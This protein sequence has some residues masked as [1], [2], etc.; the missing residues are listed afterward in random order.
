MEWQNDYGFSNPS[1]A[2][3]G[4]KIRAPFGLFEKLRQI[5]F[6]G[7]EQFGKQ[8]GGGVVVADEGVSHEGEEGGVAVAG[9]CCFNSELLVVFDSG[10]EA[11][12]GAR[13]W[14]RNKRAVAGGVDEAEGFN[15]S[16]VGQ[17]FYGAAVGDVGGK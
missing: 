12:D 13:R 14:G 1:D 11:P 7:F 16:V 9:D 3:D 15:D 8:R 6:V 4:L 10:D 17:E 5:F 2:K